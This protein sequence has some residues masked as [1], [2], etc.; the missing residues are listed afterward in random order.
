MNVLMTHN[1]TMVDRKLVINI[2][3]FNLEYQQ[4][5][6]SGVVTKIA[7]RKPEKTKQKKKPND[8]NL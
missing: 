3:I 2:N 4:P 6:L 7:S 5:Q 1:L 8:D